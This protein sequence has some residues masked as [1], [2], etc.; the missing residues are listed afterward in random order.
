MKSE[1]GKA[2]AREAASD[3]DDETAAGGVDEDEVGKPVL[4]LTKK[5]QE[6]FPFLSAI[7][8]TT[9]PGISS[10]RKE[11]Q[12]QQQQPAAAAAAAAAAVAKSAKQSDAEKKEDEKAAA[13]AST[14]SRSQSP[15]VAISPKVLIACMQGDLYLYCTADRYSTIRFFGLVSRTVF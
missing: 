3:A 6:L 11:Q 5:Q 1:D 7:R 2:K 12:Q 4:Q 13:A 14:R 10:S 15:S 9:V 8:T